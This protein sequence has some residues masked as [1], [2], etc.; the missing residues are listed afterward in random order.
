MSDN[1]KPELKIYIF[2]LFAWVIFPLTALWIWVIYPNK[3][4]LILKKEVCGTW[5]SK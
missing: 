3:C 2:V 4:A 1:Q 5:W